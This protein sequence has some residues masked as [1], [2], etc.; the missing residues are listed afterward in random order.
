[1]G[2]GGRKIVGLSF[3]IVKT[4][5]ARGQGGGRGVDMYNI[6]NSMSTTPQEEVGDVAFRS[7]YCS[8]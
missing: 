3:D 1:M 2:G 4:D 5:I 8:S 7:L 6:H